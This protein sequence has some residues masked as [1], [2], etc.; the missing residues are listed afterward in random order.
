[1]KNHLIAICCCLVFT[2]GC[3]RHYFTVS[4]NTMNVYLDESISKNV[5]F[6]CSLDDFELREPLFIDGHWV[7][8]LPSTSPFKYFYV[9]DEKIYVPDCRMKEKDD[10]G[11][12]NC[13]FE[14]YM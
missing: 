1:M 11:S 7:V 6:A 9:I 13:V 8:S 10:F 5:L 2:C 14:P 4:G 12:E 3:S